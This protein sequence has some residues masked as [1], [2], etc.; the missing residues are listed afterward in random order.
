M[1]SLW[2]EQ[3][4]EQRGTPTHIHWSHTL[5]GHTHQGHPQAPRVHILSSPGH[6]TVRTL[7]GRGFLRPVEIPVSWGLLFQEPD[8]Q[9]HRCLYSVF[10]SAR[11]RQSA[12]L[13]ATFILSGLG[14]QSPAWPGIPLAGC[15]GGGS[16]V[17]RE[18]FGAGRGPVVHPGAWLGGRELSVSPLR[19]CPLRACPL[20]LF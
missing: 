12:P 5:Q 17:V 9:R 19:A 3:E 10:I 2:K 18:V 8:S 4:K 11:T 6:G 14:W 13:H 20:Q 1:G 7:P 15:G 16:S